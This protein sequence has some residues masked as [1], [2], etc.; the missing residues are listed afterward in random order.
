MARRSDHSREE[1][2]E[3]ALGAAEEIIAREGYGALTARRLAGAIG[4]TVGTLYL[5]FKNLDDLIL[6]VNARSLEELYE[7]LT[8]ATVDSSPGVERTLALAHAYL[9]FAREQRH[10]FRLIFQLR[11]AEQGD[12]PDWYVARVGRLFAPVEEAIAP[13]AAGAD[14]DEIAQH[15]RTLWSGV[16][17]IV[18]LALMG[19]TTVVQAESVEAMIDALVENYLVGLSHRRDA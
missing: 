5:V 15:A 2:R 11:V 8:A 3:M 12:P 16:H 10:R 18:V 6:Q 19:G 1:I 4:Y 14:A 9:A 13:L 7:H 17:G